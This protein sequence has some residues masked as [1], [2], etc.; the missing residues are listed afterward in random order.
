MAFAHDLLKEAHHLAQRGGRN[1]KQASLRRAVSTAYYALFHLLIGDFVANW[2]VKSQR[3]KL[4]RLFEHGRMKSTS[5]NI[6]EKTPVNSTDTGKKLRIVATA[7]VWLQQRRHEADYDN[8]K[9]WSRS[10][11]IVVRL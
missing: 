6:S 8:G 1:P 11:V 9:I 4:A 3:L 7:F 10:N 5:K 2:K